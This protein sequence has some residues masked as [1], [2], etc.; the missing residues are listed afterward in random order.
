MNSEGIKDMTARLTFALMRPHLASKNW[1]N[2]Y[3]DD[4]KISG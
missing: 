2:N 4:S 3:R 1:I